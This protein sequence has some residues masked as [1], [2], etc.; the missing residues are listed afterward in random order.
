MD[1]SRKFTGKSI[2]NYCDRDDGNSTSAFP[3][4]MAKNGAICLHGV[5]RSNLNLKTHKIRVQKTFLLVF[6]VVLSSFRWGFFNSF[7]HF[8]CAC[9]FTGFGDSPERWPA[10]GRN[11]LVVE[12]R[13][14]L[15]FNATRFQPYFI[16]PSMFIQIIFIFLSLKE[17]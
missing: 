2:Q 7:F 6:N 13:H 11:I 14:K 4:S 15:F 5:K 1:K 17:D 10:S 3:F 9:F 8:A 12:Q 16:S